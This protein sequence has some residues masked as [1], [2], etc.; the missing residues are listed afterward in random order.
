MTRLAS[1]ALAVA[2]LAVAGARRGAAQATTERAA[3]T[4][5][6]DSLREVHDTTV[7]RQLE[8]RWK[9]RFGA[10]HSDA[11]SA[12]RLGFVQ[13]RLGEVQ[14]RP[15]PFDDAEKTFNEVITAHPDWDVAWLGHDLA[16]ANELDDR[17]ATGRDAKLQTGAFAQG[18]KADRSGAVVDSQSVEGLARIVDLAL[19][20]YKANRLSAALAAAR[21]FARGPAGTLPAAELARA[22]I[23]RVAG[24]LDSATRVVRALLVASPDDPAALMEA[25]HIALL[26]GDDAGAG[27]WFR[28]LALADSVAA[29]RYRDD[30]LE[31]LPDSVMRQ[32]DATRGVAR[33]NAIRAFFAV[34]EFG[35]RR[36]EVNRLREHYQRLDEARRE[37]VLPAPNF[38]A[39]AVVSSEVERHEMDERGAVWVLHGRPDHRTH[40]SMVSAPP[41][42]SWQYKLDDGGELLFHFVKT[43]N[44]RGYRRVA[45]LL[46]VLAMTRPLQA[47]GHSD[48]AAMAAR[49][50]ALQT[51]GASWT[52]QTV[53]DMLYSREAISPTYGRMLSRGRNGA[54]AL[55]LEERAAGDSSIRRGETESVRFELPLDAEFD[56]VAVGSDSGSQFMQ[57]AFAIPGSSLY[58]PPEVRPVV[59]RIRMRVSIIQQGSGRVVASIDTTRNFVAAEPVP[60]DGSLFGRLPVRVPAGNYSVRIALS[61]PSRGVMGPRQVVRVADGATATIDLSDLALGAR[62]VRLPWR[63]PRG[64]SV[65]MNPART[66][67]IGEPMQLYFEVLGLHAGTPYTV[68]LAVFP[69]GKARA[70]LQLGFSVTASGSPDPVSRAV[71]LGRL[72]AGT[73]ELQVTASTASGQRVVR[74]GEFTVVK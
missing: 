70:T 25:G 56:A 32:F 34:D 36:S 48:L 22:R 4:K 5:F 30:L 33:E 46:D 50:E 10:Q 13:L 35:M 44:V 31:L 58:A 23:E 11:M 19:R 53:Q 49:G 15:G 24:S 41:N 45:S 40:L 57:I 60:L 67:R 29:L 27:L 61:T 28:G 51:Y 47:T 38:R 2:L 16:R 42:E 65:W 12:L 43:D 52:A 69:T 39:D 64:D 68:S 72:G 6:R 37:F 1:A 59:Y 62:S 17:G 73:Y 26:R 63:T 20:D 7:L 54:L 18:R 55:Q 21:R 66:F 71:D 14:Q 74:R 3:L 8:H 9:D